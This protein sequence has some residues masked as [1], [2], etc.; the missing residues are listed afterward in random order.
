MTR[1]DFRLG[2]R[3]GSETLQTDGF[4]QGESGAR[5]SFS[6]DLLGPLGFSGAVEDVGQS[7]RR[8]SSEELGE[9]QE[10]AMISPT[11]QVLPVL[12]G[13]SSV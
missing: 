2:L 8:K 5:R 6:T 7:R 9:N 4:A 12:I 11:K 10:R 1:G 13:F 3:F